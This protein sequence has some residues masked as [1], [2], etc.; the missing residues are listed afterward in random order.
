MGHAITPEIEATA[1]QIEAA[2]GSAW[3]KFT[4]N[5]FNPS[6]SPDGLTSLEAVIDRAWKA[7]LANDLVSAVS[8][9]LPPL[10]AQEL[11]RQRLE[12][13]E[14]GGAGDATSAPMPPLPPP[15]SRRP[16]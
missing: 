11:Q 2:I 8:A 16:R 13:I 12:V 3:R 9:E 10:T 5:Y 15:D 7:F 14:G 4:Y 6:W 1:E